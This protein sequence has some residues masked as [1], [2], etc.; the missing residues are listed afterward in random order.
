MK[1]KAGCDAL[2]AQM[3]EKET[4]L[5]VL[6]NNSGA[7]WV[8]RCCEGEEEE[9]GSEL[10]LTLFVPSRPFSFVFFRPLKGSPLTDT[11]EKNGWDK[12]MELNVKR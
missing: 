1:D 4:K 12:I 10:E 5:D 9:E 8:S 7:T 2:A 6:V 3:K 11:P